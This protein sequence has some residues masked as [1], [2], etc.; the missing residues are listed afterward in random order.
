MTRK[1]V[2]QVLLLASAVALSG[3]TAGEGV[4][5][6]SSSHDSSQAQSWTAQA[7]AVM[8]TTSFA[9]VTRA[10]FY[11]GNGRRYYTLWDDDDVVQVYKGDN[12]VGTM[13]PPE[14]SKGNYRATLTGTLT[15]TFNEGDVLDLYMPTRAMDFT[16]Q[17]GALYGD[18]GLSK[19]YAFQHATTTVAAADAGNQILQLDA[20]GMSHRAAYFIFVL[21]DV[22]TGDRLHP[23]S[24]E[25]T[26]VDG[27]LVQS[28]NDA[29]EVTK[30][31]LT[32][33]PALENGEYPSE[34]FISLLNETNANVSY[35]LKATVGTDTY[36]NTT[37]VSFNPL[38]RLGRLGRVARNMRKTSPV[39][40]LTIVDVPDQV[41]TGYAIEPVLTVMDGVTV[42]TLNTD[43][44]TSYTDNI[45]VGQAT[46]TAT[47]LADAGAMAAT[48]YMGKQ[49]KAFNIVKATPVIE[50]DNSAM[51]V[52]Y[53]HPGKTR[54]VSR[55]FIDNNG[56]GT[57]DEGID[58]DI[59]ALC[60]VTYT[61]GDLNIVN[62]DPSTGEVSSP[63][64][65]GE[66]TITATVAEA[67]N[68]NSKTATY[69]VHAESEMNSDNSVTDWDNGGTDNGKVILE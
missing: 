14:S 6:F 52:V 58:Y 42:L 28:V 64:G 40:P 48:K 62:V 9:D 51:E 43:Y 59:T 57:W 27:N 18:N 44:A 22:D 46:A 3:C 21:Q 47:G 67:A 35:R 10:V 26:A 56:N 13:T 15:G 65:L 25:I 63:V 33:T 24:V 31:S 60:T 16:G 7:E 54:T 55:V 4:D 38:S 8:D 50:M 45:N 11:G 69:S 61:S 32:I 41:F 17:A 30:G 66:T 29:G 12:A 53:N 49:D 34:L 5:L 2:C 19:K 1:K 20:V 37:A 23:S 36:I 39:S 68:W